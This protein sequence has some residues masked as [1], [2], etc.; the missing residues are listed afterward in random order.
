MRRVW[1]GFLPIANPGSSQ[2][3][4]HGRVSSQMPGV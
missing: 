1:Q 2:N 3:P 4:P